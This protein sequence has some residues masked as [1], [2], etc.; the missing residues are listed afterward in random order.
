MPISSSIS[1]IWLRFDRSR[2]LSFIFLFFRKDF[3]YVF[4]LPNDILCTSRS[5]DNH[6]AAG[7]VS[8][9]AFGIHYNQANLH[10]IDGPAARH[11]CPVVSISGSIS[12]IWLQFDRSRLIRVHLWLRIN[13][14]CLASHLPD[15]RR[16]GDS[17][18]ECRGRTFHP[19]TADAC[20]QPAGHECL[21]AGPSIR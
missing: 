8:S 2:L 11:S 21:A 1:I 5:D 19:Q 14:L 4:E 9:S 3:P 13:V 7:A 6:R 17:S 16:C 10:L 15:T 12:I 18:A 20:W